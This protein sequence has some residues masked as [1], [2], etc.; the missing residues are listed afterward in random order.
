VGDYAMD[1]KYI[2]GF[3]DAKGSVMLL[4]Y[5]VKKY[6]NGVRFSPRIVITTSNKNLLIK[7]HKTLEIGT[8]KGCTPTA[9]YCL[10]I[11]SQ[12][13]CK[14]FIDRTLP[15][16]TVKKPQLLLLKDALSLLENKKS[17]QINLYDKQV[18]LEITEQ[19]RSVH[20]KTRKNRQDIAIF[21]Q[22]IDTLINDNL[23]EFLSFSIQ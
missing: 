18:L 9:V 11:S 7:I 13:E 8:I 20:G 2:T 19:L 21:K 5:K 12:E 16:S 23:T 6:R 4:T 14:K 15:Y 1:I 10:V 17:N 22:E 3:F